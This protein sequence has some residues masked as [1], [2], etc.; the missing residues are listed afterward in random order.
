MTERL[1]LA[2]MDVYVTRFTAE[3]TALGQTAAQ[4]SAVDRILSEIAGSGYKLCH[5]DDGSPYI[6]RFCREITISHCKGIAAVGVGGDSRIGIDIEI[7]RAQLRRV[8]RKFL[9]EEEQRRFTTDDDL[10]T[11]WTMKEALYK[12][13]GI[14]GIDFANGVTLPPDGS[15]IT[16]IAGRHYRVETTVIFNARITAASPVGDQSLVP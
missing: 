3:E 6:D 8:T 5:N 11:A 7:P 15:D 13:V 10:L 4:K 16:E 12:A 14:A 1:R 2:G 9:S